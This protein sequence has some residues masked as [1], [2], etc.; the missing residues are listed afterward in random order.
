MRNKIEKIEFKNE[1]GNLSLDISGVRFMDFTENEKIKLFL[2]LQ[3]I[4]NSDK[5]AQR[6]LSEIEKWNLTF[7]RW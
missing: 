3:E 2:L 1:N 6:K 4:C 5:V 7:T